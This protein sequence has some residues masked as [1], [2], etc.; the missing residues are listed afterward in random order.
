MPPV[1]TGSVVAVIGLNLAPI[2]VKG[3][4]GSALDTWIGI[5]T[6]VAVGLVAV[7]A[8]GL[9]QR[10]PILLGGLA[11]LRCSTRSARTSSGLGKPIDFAAVGGGGV[12]RLAALHGAG[13]E[14]AGDR[15]DRAGRDRPGRRE[16]RPHQG[17]RGDDR[18]QPRPVPGPR[19]HRRRH[20]RRSSRARAAARASRPT[21]R[22][23]A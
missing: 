19:V 22:T 11:G 20:S 13:V 3:I 15:A 6:I 5:A 14:R 7:R 18:P 2:A 21:P 1:V 23:S 8:P 9:A 16:P 17:R 4:S 12:D 10:L